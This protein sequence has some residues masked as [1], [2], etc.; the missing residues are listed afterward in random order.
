MKRIILP[1]DFSENAYNAITFALELYKKET[2]TFYLLHTYTPAIYMAEY[3]LHSPGQIGLGDIYQEDSLSKLEKLKAKITKQFKN[4]KH[5]FILHAAFNTLVDEISKTILS[6]KADIVIMGT[7]GATGAKEILLGTNTVHVI[8]KATC[9]VIAVPANFEYENPKEILFPTDYEID[10]RTIP[11]N[12]LI[13]IAESHLSRIEVL[14]VST[15]YPLSEQ[16][17]KNKKKLVRILDKTPHLF[18]D[19]PNEEVIEAINGFQLKNRMNLLVMVQ[20]K[21]TFLE[22]LFLEP[23]IKKIGFH[24]TIPFMIIQHH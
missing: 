22:R 16:Q 12:E 14:H 9:P 4:P 15:G 2:A 18:H 11:F 1:T 8:K 19:L 10:Y 3:V 6:E 24:V 23:V 13:D 7:Q 5:S 20:N 17:E 21:H